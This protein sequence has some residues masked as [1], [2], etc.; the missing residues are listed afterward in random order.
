MNRDTARAALLQAA[1]L[2]ELAAADDHT[3]EELR[4]ELAPGDRVA[5]PDLGFVQMTQP[6]K[7]WRVADYTALNAWIET[8]CPEAIVS[9][10][11]VSPAFVSSL[12]KS[13]EYVTSDGE[14]LTPDGIGAV[15][16]QPTL[17]VSPTDAAHEQ[18]RVILGR[19]D[20]AAIEAD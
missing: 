15:E 10:T 13:G 3:R 12:L 18:A 20:V 2:K 17:R 14:V 16:G 1:I 8:N 5:V 11:Q 7:G 19:L 9:V 6:R 4:A